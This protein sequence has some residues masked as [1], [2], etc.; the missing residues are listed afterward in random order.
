[1]YNQYIHFGMLICQMWLQ[2]MDSW[3]FYFAFCEYSHIIKYHS[4][5]RWCILTKLSQTVCLVNTHIL[6][7]RYGR[8]D[9]RLLKVLWF[10][11]VFLEFSY[12]MTCLK[13]YIFTKLSQTVYLVIVHSYIAYNPATL[14]LFAIE[15]KSVQTPGF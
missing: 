3:F 4:C 10:I 5:L 11:F 9:C 1:M 2:V 6:V 13:G 12:I 7:Y 15:G 8:C 14:Y